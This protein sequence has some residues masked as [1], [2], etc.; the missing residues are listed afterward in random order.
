MGQSQVPT[1]QIFIK[2]FDFGFLTQREPTVQ[3]FE[4]NGDGEKVLVWCNHAE[5]ETQV[6]EH[7][8]YIPDGRDIIY[9]TT[10][11]VCIKENC[12][13]YKLE[14]AREWEDAPERG[15]R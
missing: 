14:G 6:D 11:L 10:T 5:A 13:A 9:T 12:Q 4:L 7:E 15:I 8:I 3:Y 1:K 2:N